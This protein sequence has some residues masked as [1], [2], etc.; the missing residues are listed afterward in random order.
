M[1][2]HKNSKVVAHSTTTQGLAQ[3][4]AIME[5]RAGGLTIWF[6]FR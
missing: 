3:R 1:K 5:E 4:Q 6:M 2:S